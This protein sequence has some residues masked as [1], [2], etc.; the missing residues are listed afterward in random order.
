MDGEIPKYQADS[1]SGIFASPAVN[2][3]DPYRHDSR[4]VTSNGN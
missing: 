2:R 4:D 3:C 1:D